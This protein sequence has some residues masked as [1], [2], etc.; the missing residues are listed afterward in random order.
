MVC[1][2]FLAQTVRAPEQNKIWELVKE[3]VSQEVDICGFQQANVWQ[4]EQ[5]K[6]LADSFYRYYPIAQLASFGIFSTELIPSRY[7]II[8]LFVAHRLWNDTPGYRFEKMFR[9]FLLVNRDGRYAGAT[10]SNLDEDLQTLAEAHDFSEALTELLRRL[11]VS[12]VISQED[13]LTRYDQAAGSRF[14]MLML[15]LALRDRGAKD[16]VDGTPIGYGDTLSGLTE[17]FRPNWYHIYPE[18]ELGGAGIDG[19]KMHWFGN[20]TVFNQQTNVSNLSNTVPARYLAQYKI[21]SEALYAHFVPT[22]FIEPVK[23]GE[24]LE[25]RWGAANYADFVLGRSAELA[26]GM[27]EFLRRLE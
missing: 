23:A 13:L 14:M 25:E 27:T 24:S 7:S 17:R 19:D 8:P 15:Y 2:N 1:V 16:W 10:I 26:K 12:F 4:P 9:W 21:T 6:L 11:R 5:A 20:I 18:S 22:P 3:S